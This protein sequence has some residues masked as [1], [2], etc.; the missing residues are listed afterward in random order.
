V[1][2][3]LMGFFG[4]LSRAAHETV[5]RGLAYFLRNPPGAMG[6]AFDR[7]LLGWAGAFRSMA[8]IDEAQRRL[9]SDQARYRESRPGTVWP[10]GTIVLYS[11]LAFV[12]FLLVYLL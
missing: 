2:G 6:L 8:A 12:I 11:A 10:I 1:E 9:V 7:F 5:P 4:A 3:P